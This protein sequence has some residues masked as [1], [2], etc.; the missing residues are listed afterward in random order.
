MRALC[1]YDHE[2][3]DDDI[4]D[5]D[6]GNQPDNDFHHTSCGD[7]FLARRAASWGIIVYDGAR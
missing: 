6:F 1:D 2:D 7:F 4:E 3:A 5:D